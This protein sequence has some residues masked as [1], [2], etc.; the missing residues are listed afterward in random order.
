MADLAWPDGI[1]PGL[2]EPVAFLLERDEEMESRLGELG[3]RFFLTKDRLIWYMEE[4]V[5]VDIDGDEIVGSVEVEPVSGV[6]S[7]AGTEGSLIALDMAE[8][9][10]PESTERSWTHKEIRRRV[11]TQFLDDAVDGF[12]EWLLA[13]EGCEMRHLVNSNHSVYRG[14]RRILFFY[15][16]ERW[17]YFRL[18]HATQSE[19]EPLQALQGGITHHPH[20]KT[21]SGR[22]HSDEE[23]ELLKTA[24]RARVLAASG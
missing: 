10:G 1:Q 6:H 22:I 24:V 4:I 13:L 7:Q 21:I 2:T 20:R 5:G 18:P 3:Y 9:A 23:L 19:S 12:E 8:E 15:F 11:Q 14:R 16:A 17:M